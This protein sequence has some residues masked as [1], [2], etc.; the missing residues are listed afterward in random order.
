MH[1][2]KGAGLFVIG[3]F[4]QVASLLANS[5][6]D[7]ALLVDKNIAAV[8]YARFR[9]ALAELSGTRQDYI[10][11]LT[12]R[13]VDLK[14]L[15]E[16][17]CAERLN[18]E[19]I[20]EMGDRLINLY[21]VSSMI[22]GLI[23]SDTG[24]SYS[25]D[26]LRSHLNQEYWSLR[27]FLEHNPSSWLSNEAKYQKLRRMYSDGRIKFA[28][29]DLFEEG[30]SLDGE[31]EFSLVYLSNVHEYAELGE[32]MHTF[33]ENL[34]NLQVSRDSLWVMTTTLG[35]G[36]GILIGGHA[37]QLGYLERSKKALDSHNC[38]QKASYLLRHR[39][40]GVP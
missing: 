25:D 30:L 31:E 3:G 2:V 8:E 10:S 37:L 39:D 6:L 21:G 29:V 33:H 32:R 27:D 5:D 19:A 40:S 20:L 1:G 18:K 9:C 4:D 12:S 16:S 36:R 34:G 38:A 14:S 17:F 28:L 35:G 13:K 24:Y 23:L 11:N 7:S 26:M 22:I 15:E